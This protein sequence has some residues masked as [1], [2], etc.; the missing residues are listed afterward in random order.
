MPCLV[1]WVFLVHQLLNPHAHMDINQDPDKGLR[2]SPQKN[3]KVLATLFWQLLFSLFPSSPTAEC[4][5]RLSHHD[6]SHTSAT[7][8]A[9]TGGLVAGG[10][11]R[12]SLQGAAQLVMSRTRPVVALLCNAPVSNCVIRRGKNSLGN[13]PHHQW[14]WNTWRRRE[15]EGVEGGTTPSATWLHHP[16]HAKVV[17]REA[18]S[19][20]VAHQSTWQRC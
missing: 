14:K 2:G 3:C 9:G 10:R 13:S 11:A 1:L 18:R 8:P 19:S 6:D 7:A 15:S 16:C 17:C 5:R 4:G 12:E 20:Q